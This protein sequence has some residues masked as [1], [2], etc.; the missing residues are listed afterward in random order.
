MK[1]SSFPAK[2]SLPVRVLRKIPGWLGLCV[3]SVWF[4]LLML[5]PAAGVLLVMAQNIRGF[6]DWYCGSVYR[7]VSVFWNRIS[8]ILP[9][10]FGEILL[11]LLPL[12]LLTY[13]VLV[14]VRIVKG[15][16]RRLKTVGKGFLRLIAFGS[17]IFFLFVTNCG[18]NYYCTDVISLMGLQTTKRSAE[19]LQ[20]VCIYYADRAA[21]LRRELP[22]NEEGVMT[23]DTTQ[24]AYDAA[25]AVNALHGRYSFIAD[26]YSRPKKVML[27]RG[28]SYLN[29]TGVYFPFTFEANINA[30]APAAT[31]PFTM[32]HELA[33]VRGIMHEEDA[34]LVAYLSCIYS[35]KPEVQYSGYLMAL[36]Y[37]AGHLYR[38]DKELYAAYESH[39]TDAIHRDLRNYSSYWAQFETPVAKTAAKVNDTYLKSNAQKSGIKSYGLI[40]D[41]MIAHYYQE[42]KPAL[43][44]E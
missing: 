33:H 35:D 43:S 39:L 12:G 13:L 15:K 36:I 42:I 41:L 26:G 7:I 23:L 18:I 9:V 29:I 21:E 31:I 27:S 38:A 32:C 37:C 17:L 16:G 40:T 1:E 25:E 28:M 30:D 2:P 22:E 44:E 24:A 34:N 6:A 4:W 10:S 8:G 3:R 11:M 14:M 20:E 5:L 19:E